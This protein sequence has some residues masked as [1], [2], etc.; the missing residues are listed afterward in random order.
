[1]S[2]GDRTQ[3]FNEV[4]TGRS[5]KLATP[6]AP[7]DHYRKAVGSYELRTSVSLAQFGVSSQ[8]DEMIEVQG[9]NQK[10]FRIYQP[11]NDGLECVRQ[12]SHIH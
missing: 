10:R 11:I 3:R 9:A 2:G 6:D 1:M 12:V 8:L 7:K 4:R 5:L